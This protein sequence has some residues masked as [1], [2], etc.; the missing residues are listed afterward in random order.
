MN[1]V[2]L[3][4]ALACSM[5][6]ALADYQ[7]HVCY[8]SQLNIVDNRLGPEGAKAL[9][10]ALVRSSLTKI[11]VGSNKLGDEGTI[12]LCDAL[13]ES[14]V[15]KVEELDMYN[16]KI[17]PNGAK[18]IAAL[19]VV[20]ASLTRVDVSYNSMTD[21]GVDLLRDAVSGREGFELMDDDN[22]GS[23]DSDSDG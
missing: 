22:D 9:A 2:C 19:C 17:G 6:L 18:A 13:R 4:F 1:H 7:L 8:R 11:L 16:N 3:H 23:D 20:A 21:E 12:I 5:C 14:T 10:P 15:S